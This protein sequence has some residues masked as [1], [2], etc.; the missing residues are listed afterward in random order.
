MIP[1]KKR[2]IVIIMKIK[3][4][5]LFNFKASIKFIKL[6]AKHHLTKANTIPDVQTD[7]IK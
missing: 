6:P 7:F 3:K 5:L 4:S 2:P 1:M